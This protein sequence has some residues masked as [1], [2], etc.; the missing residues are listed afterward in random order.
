M[1]AGYRI[2]AS[3]IEK[4]RGSGLWLSVDAGGRL[5]CSS[6]MLSPCTVGR[7]RLMCDIFAGRDCYFLVS[8]LGRWFGFP[9]RMAR[10]KN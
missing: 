1:H 3:S 8:V 5:V 4:L 2:R 7:G 6:K 9:R 10:S